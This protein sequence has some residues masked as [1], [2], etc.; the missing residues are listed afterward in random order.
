MSHGKSK[1]FLALNPMPRQGLSCFQFSGAG[2]WGEEKAK[3]KKDGGRLFQVSK[4]DNQ[5]KICTNSSPP[6]FHITDVTVITESAEELISGFKKMQWVE[7]RK[8][9]NQQEKDTKDFLKQKEKNK[10]AKQA[11]KQK[12]MELTCFQGKGIWEACSQTGAY[13]HRRTMQKPGGCEDG[14]R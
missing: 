2:R 5:K 10:F 9:I 3:E 12:R 4:T 14:S 8:Y 1:D 13:G 7:Q 6:Q 11:W